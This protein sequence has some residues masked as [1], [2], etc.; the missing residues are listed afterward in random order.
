[1]R[2]RIPKRGYLRDCSTTANL[3]IDSSVVWYLLIEV[4]FWWMIKLKYLEEIKEVLSIT[5]SLTVTVAHRCAAKS[6]PNTSV[7]QP[8]PRQFSMNIQIRAS[9]G[10]FW[11]HT[12]LMI[13]LPFRLWYLN[14]RKRGND[15]EGLA[16]VEKLC[17]LPVSSFPHSAAFSFL[18]FYFYLKELHDV[19]RMHARL[20]HRVLAGEGLWASAFVVHIS[21]PHKTSNHADA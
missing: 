16:W 3:D 10:S 7:S 17:F 13:A 8:N 20:G 11:G 6:S 1:M 19:L 14:S 12:N 18:K 21:R 15:L 9:S 2:E 5:F 4:F